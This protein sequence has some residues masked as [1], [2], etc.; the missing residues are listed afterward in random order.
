MHELKM[1]SLWRDRDGRGRIVIIRVPEFEG[2]VCVRTWTRGGKVPSRRPE[3]WVNITSFHRRFVWVSDMVEVPAVPSQIKGDT[4]DQ[5]QV[6]QE[7]ELPLYRCPSH[8][9]GK[10][11]WIGNAEDVE[12]PACL[13]EV[14]GELVGSV[15][16]KV[17]KIENHGG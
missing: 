13:S 12:C 8:R 2:N 10:G 14:T 15:T 16:V 4:G 3:T 17:I 6:G 1:G 7:R 11:T 5:V 9:C